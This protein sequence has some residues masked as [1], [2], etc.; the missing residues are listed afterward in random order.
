VLTDL[1]TTVG[2]DAVVGLYLM[3][4]ADKVQKAH[5]VVGAVVKAVLVAQVWL[6][7]HIFKINSLQEFRR[8]NK[9]Q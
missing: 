4:P 5:T 3:R 2:L 9:C 6:K 7:L 1:S 8:Y